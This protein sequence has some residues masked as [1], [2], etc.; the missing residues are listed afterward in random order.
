L[1]YQIDHSEEYAIKMLHAA[2]IKV[3]RVV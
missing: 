1:Y 3:H 2:G